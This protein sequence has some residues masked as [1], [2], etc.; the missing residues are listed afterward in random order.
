MVMLDE[1]MM[2]QD[3]LS[4]AK[5]FMPE[6]STTWAVSKWALKQKLE[7]YETIKKFRRSLKL[8]ELSQS[9]STQSN[10]FSAAIL[11][12]Q[13]E[14]F[15][16]SDNSS[17]SSSRKCLCREVHHWRK[18]PYLVKKNQSKGWKLDSKIIA[19]IKQKI[20]SSKGLQY[21]IKKFLDT[22]FFGEIGTSLSGSANNSTPA[23]NS[24]DH[25]EVSQQ[26]QRL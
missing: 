22:K 18:C 25:T 13:S 2:A 1:E 23:P 16:K 10:I 4:V 6:F 9:T 21:I 17:P 3:F 14:S 19:S 20:E 5:K 24:D 7:L 8:S 26:K 15:P 12:G 11:Q